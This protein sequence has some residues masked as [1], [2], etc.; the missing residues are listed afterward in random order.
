MSR[1]ADFSLQA[2][3]ELLPLLPDLQRVLQDAYGDASARHDRQALAGDIRRMNQVIQDVIEACPAA[4]PAAKRDPVRIGEELTIEP[5]DGHFHLYVGGEFQRPMTAME[6]LLMNMML[7][8]RKRAIEV[9]IK[10]APEKVR[11][12]AEPDAALSF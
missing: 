2:A 3:R 5:V 1:S 7:I 4:E 11:Q 12:F 8:E 9:G 10:N 6:E